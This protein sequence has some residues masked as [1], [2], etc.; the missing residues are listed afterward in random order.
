MW[1][2][3]LYFFSLP[4]FGTFAYDHYLK[5]YTDEPYTSSAAELLKDYK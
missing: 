1:I 5:H 3:T 4:F 2:A